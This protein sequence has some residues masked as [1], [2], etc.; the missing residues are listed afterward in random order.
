MK[1]SVNYAVTFIISTIWTLKTNKR[2][3]ERE[4][5]PFQTIVQM[6]VLPSET[7]YVGQ[8]FSGGRGGGKKRL[9]TY[10]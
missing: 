2:Y 4:E 10:Q 3:K 6:F 8:L 7:H 9:K 1:Q 5:E